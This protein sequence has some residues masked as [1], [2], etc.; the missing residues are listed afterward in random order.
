MRHPAKTS[1]IIVFMAIVVSYGHP[2]L[3]WG[4]PVS[5]VQQGHAA[6]QAAWQREFEEIC[7]RTME[8][9]DLSIA[10]LRALIE[11]CDK[12]SAAIDQLEETQKKVYQR[13][14]K[15]CRDMYVFALESKEAKK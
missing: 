11:R 14:L 6:A 12:I 10:E 7:S 4:G 5:F 2:A 15:M 9:M 13:R 1:V 3:H 8:A